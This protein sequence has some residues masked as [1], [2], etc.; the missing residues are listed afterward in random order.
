MKN[1]NRFILA[2]TVL[3]FLTIPLLGMKTFKRFLPGSLFMSLYLIGEGR[4]AEKRKWWWFPFKVKPNVLGEMP[5]I[6]GPFFVGSL[7]ILKYTF[8]K[9]NLYLLVN[10]IVDSIFTYFGLD[11]L[12]KVGYVSLVRL[13]KVQL[14]IVFLIKTFILY[15]FQMVYEKYLR[16][17]SKD[18]V[19]K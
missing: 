2:M 17:P 19:S 6:I 7:W 8:G 15:G 5:L 16:S 18:S 1:L 12:K 9:F 10:V 14:S 3:P 11:W 4:F 13:S